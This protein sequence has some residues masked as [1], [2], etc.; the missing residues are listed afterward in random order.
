MNTPH[1]RR[2]SMLL[3]VAADDEYNPAYITGRVLIDFVG[4]SCDGGGVYE[5][6]MQQSVP[7]RDSKDSFTKRI[8]IQ[9]QLTLS[10]RCSALAFH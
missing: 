6:P 10:F 8:P 1:L 2:R 7:P 3:S 5:G 4:A 9:S